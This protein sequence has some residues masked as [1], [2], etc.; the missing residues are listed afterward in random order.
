[1]IAKNAAVA[2]LGERLATS[3]EGAFDATVPLQLTEIK[4]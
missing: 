3:Q 1:M 2:H 4:Q